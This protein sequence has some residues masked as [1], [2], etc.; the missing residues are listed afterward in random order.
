[1]ADDFSSIEAYQTLAQMHNALSKSPAELVSKH[2]ALQRERDKLAGSLAKM[3]RQ[4]EE[5][6]SGGNSVEVSGGKYDGCEGKVE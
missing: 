2:V 6:V 3:R 1:M 4:H 5:P